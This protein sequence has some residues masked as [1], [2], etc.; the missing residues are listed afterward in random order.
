VDE[1]DLDYIEQ[2]KN[3]PTAFGKIYEHYVDR[4]YNYVFQRTHDKHHAEELTARVFFQALRNLDRYHIRGVPFG[5]WL[6]RIAHNMVANWY[7]DSKRAQMVSVESLPAMQ[8]DE[9]GP[10]ESVER[11]DDLRLLQQAIARLNPD[12]QELLILKYSEGLTNAEI[13]RI[14]NRSEGA[15][16]ALYLRTLQSLRKEL[17]KMGLRSM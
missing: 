11:E 10:E 3:D 13:S 9:A 16:K 4:I 14:M 2:A 7:R 17:E 5:S 15:I 8:S 6:F 1:I 12:R